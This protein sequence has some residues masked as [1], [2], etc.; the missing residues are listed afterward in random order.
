MFCFNTF[1][2]VLSLKF[3]IVGPPKHALNSHNQH[4][5]QGP[6]LMETLANKCEVIKLATHPEGKHYMVLSREGEVYSWGS[7]DGGKLGHGDTK[8]EIEIIIPF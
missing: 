7:G 6:V 1:K 3:H 5:C 2:L 8:Y 4:L